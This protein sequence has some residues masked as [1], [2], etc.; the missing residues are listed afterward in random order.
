MIDGAWDQAGHFIDRY[1]VALF[2]TCWFMFRFERLMGILVTRVNK[3]IITQVVI[4]RTLD[5]D[6][7][8]DQLMRAAADEDSGEHNLPNGGS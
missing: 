2:V 5:L 8:Q 1:G 4:C 6:E 3:L 7:Q